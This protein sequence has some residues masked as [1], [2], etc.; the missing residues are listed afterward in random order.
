MKGIL[1]D[2]DYETRDGKAVIRLFFKG[3]EKNFILEDDSFLP[4]FYVVH[5]RIEEIKKIEKVK[6]V[7][8]EEKKLF[9]K[10]QRF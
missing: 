7:L 9:G 1:L 2:I 8:V 3:E 6:D 4:Y 5:D 10:K